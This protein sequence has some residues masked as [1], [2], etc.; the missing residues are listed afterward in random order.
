MNDVTLDHNALYHALVNRDASLDE[1]YFVAVSSTGIFCRMS[2]P[3]RKPKPENCRF[4]RSSAECLSLGFRPCKR[5]H[6]LGES[7]PMS[8]LVEALL[9]AMG[10][11][12]DGVW[13]Q[14]RLVEAGF[15]PST[16]RRAFKRHFGMTFLAFAR[17][18][19]LQRGSSALAGGA[20]VIDAQLE[21]GFD[22]GSGFRAA[23]AKL[24]SVPPA[25]LTQNHGSL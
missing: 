8:P 12:P 6:P 17:L 1:R 9:H 10:E 19:R 20:R 13:S 3:A 2:C 25:S 16:V 11:D 14:T 4:F 23:L 24:L 21:A 5:C 7:A 22:S 15:D 18:R